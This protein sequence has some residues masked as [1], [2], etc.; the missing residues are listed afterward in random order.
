MSGEEHGIDGPVKIMIDVGQAQFILEIR[1]RSQTTDQHGRIVG[2]AEIHHQ[3]CMHIRTSI[4]Q[5][6]YC[7]HRHVSALLQVEKRR[8]FDI[9]GYD[10]TNFIKGPTRPFDD[11]QMT[12]RDG[13]EAP[14]VDRN[15][16]GHGSVHLDL[17]FEFSCLSVLSDGVLD[18]LLKNAF[19][20]FCEVLAVNQ[21]QD[22]ALRIQ[23]HVNSESLD[24][25]DLSEPLTEGFSF[26][27]QCVG[28]FL[29]WSHT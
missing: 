16:M 26:W 13:I 27:I 20:L 9:V 3:T 5:V 18:V 22:T 8:L 25:V 14:S 2:L 19:L 6:G 11:I 7:I 12:V 24:A 28:R 10:H 23:S 17:C 21:D 4:G 15:R 1:N 29:R